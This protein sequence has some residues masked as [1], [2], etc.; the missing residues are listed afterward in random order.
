MNPFATT[1]RRIRIAH[2]LRQADLASRIGCEKS[3]VSALE[4]GLKGPPRQEFV[5]RLFEALPLTRAEIG[6]LTTATTVSQRKLVLELD[7]SAELYWLFAEFRDEMPHLT[8]PQVQ[9][10]RSILAFRKDGRTVDSVGSKRARAA[11]KRKSAGLESPQPSSA[12]Q[13]VTRARGR[14]GRL[15]GDSQ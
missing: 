7:A 10:I 13:P 15:E 5:R 11:G 12:E 4:I 3:Y 9:A 1:L 14:V 2:E 6:E 8:V